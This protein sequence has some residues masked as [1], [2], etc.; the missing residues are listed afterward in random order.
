MKVKL[1]NQEM[2]IIHSALYEL[3]YSLSRIEKKNK[4]VKEVIQEI[5][6]MQHKFINL[7]DRD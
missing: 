5:K 4:K 7:I 2:K 1:S 3:E 6:D